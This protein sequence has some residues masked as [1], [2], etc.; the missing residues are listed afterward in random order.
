LQT[1]KAGRSL[2]ELKFDVGSGR[3]GGFGL[4]DLANDFLF[5]FFVG[6]KN[7]LP[8]SQRGGNANDGT[9]GKDEDGLSGLGKGNALV[10]AINGSS[11]VYSNRNL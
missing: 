2:G 1:P 8:G 5:R 4:H 11:A 7:E 9:V 6:Q 3:A 10:G